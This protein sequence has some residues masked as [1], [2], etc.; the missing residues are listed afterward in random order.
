M[1]KID[2][3]ECIWEFAQKMRSSDMGLI[4]IISG[5]IQMIN[6]DTAKTR[7]NRK[8]NVSRT[9][10]ISGLRAKPLFFLFFLYVFCF[11]L[12]FFVFSKFFFR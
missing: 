1:V 2:S 7:E 6:P 10:L 5:L 3:G 4:R 8:K 12:F 9:T 11:F